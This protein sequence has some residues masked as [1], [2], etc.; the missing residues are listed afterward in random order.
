M[1]VGPNKIDRV[2][3][4]TK[5]YTTRVGA[6]PFPT[7]FSE[8]LEEKMRMKG[9]EY[10]ATTRRPRRCGWFDALLVRRAVR[11]SGIDRVAVTK[12]DV[13]DGLETLKICSGYRFRGEEIDEFPIQTAELD[14]CE[15]AYEEMDGWA[16]ST[17]KARRLEEL[18]EQA[19][20][21]L[22][23]ISE[24]VDVEVAAISVGP[25]RDEVIFTDTVL[26]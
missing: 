16:G 19:R 17:R 20:R 22:D 6:G 14:E 1:G 7:E 18:P 3:G 23:R 26:W 8:E 10:G 2:L 21:Y 24:L 5:A 11:V 13:L 12:L 4:V 25:R 9:K 15:P